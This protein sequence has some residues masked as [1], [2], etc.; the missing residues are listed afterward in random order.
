[1]GGRGEVWGEGACDEEER[2]LCLMCSSHANKEND[3]S[4][5]DHCSPVPAWDTNPLSPAGQ[6]LFV[7]QSCPCLREETEGQEGIVRKPIN[8][9]RERKTTLA[10]PSPR[11]HHATQLCNLPPFM[12]PGIT[13]TTASPCLPDSPLFS[14]PPW[15]L[16]SPQSHVDL[17]TQLLP[18]L[19]R[20]LGPSVA[21]GNQHQE[22]SWHPKAI[23]SRSMWPR[24]QAFLCSKGW[25][26]ATVTDRDKLRSLSNQLLRGYRLQE[27]HRFLSPRS[28]CLSRVSLW[29]VR[30]LFYCWPGTKLLNW[31]QG[32]KRWL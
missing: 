17:Q 6:E 19:L 13:A 28:F 10:A 11:L 18:S 25:G 3:T 22:F 5:N 29:R 26:W 24:E 4:N 21:V 9:P 30:K 2:G 8:W 12:S 23:Q 7:A 32:P 31:F 1:M 15:A 27:R 16:K 20:S 14:D